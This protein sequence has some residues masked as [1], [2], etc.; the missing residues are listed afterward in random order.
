[1]S[2][3]SPLIPG[4]DITHSGL[5]AVALD[6]KTAN[7]IEYV[8]IHSV[9]SHS[10]VVVTQAHNARFDVNVPTVT[11]N[12]CCRH[13]DF[14][15]SNDSSCSLRAVLYETREANEIGLHCLHTS[16]VFSEAFKK[17]KPVHRMTWRK[18]D[19]LRETSYKLL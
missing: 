4:P 8:L 15:N 6:V 5:S 14:T 2:A 1:M 19:W 12:C 18:G 10:V 11:F 3:P 16:L 7:S 9:R 17:S 13:A